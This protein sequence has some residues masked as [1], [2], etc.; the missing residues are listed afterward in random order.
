[1]IDKLKI[2][3]RL[4]S[5]ISVLLL[6]ACSGGNK[7]DS[8][9]QKDAEPIV[10]ES[11]PIAINAEAKMLLDYLN[12]QGDYVNSRDF[13]SMIKTST[14]H[15]ELG[16]NI[17]IIDLRDAET[18]KNGHIKNAVNIS[19]S[20]LPNY[21]AND[22]KPADYDK[23]VLVCYAG[24]IASYAT[25]LL[26]L[27]G[28]NNVYSMM[29]GMS[30]WNK[31]FANDWWLKKVSGQ[32]EDKLEQTIRDKSAPHDLPVM[33]TGKTTGKEI[34]NARIKSL[35][36]A[37]TGSIFI[38][39][40]SIFNQPQKYYVIN[41]DRRD[42]YE[43]GHI[44]GAIRYKPNGT[45]GIIDEMETIPASKEVVTYCQTGQNSGFVTA[46]LRLFGY[47]AKSLIFGSNSFMHNKML[48][49][50][51]SFAWHPFTDADIENYPYVK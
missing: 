12:E 41:Y 44:P 16:G 6:A 5:L 3:F 33:N 39:A 36:E 46:Y 50:K 18:F 34:F 20:K 22:I 14:V 19:F 1:M 11:K 23:I 8:I 31:D 15:D 4:F 48:A 42:K 32:Y 47:N 2:N 13:P 43:D 49:E 30:S 27:M 45:L 26:R 10:N 37:G 17:K 21:F 51:V 9:Q 29:W 7:N 24:Q 38:N 40:D 28:Y 35:F 25:L